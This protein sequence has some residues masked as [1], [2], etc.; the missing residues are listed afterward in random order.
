MVLCTVIAAVFA[1]GVGILIA[2]VG[3]VYTGVRESEKARESGKVIVPH[4]GDMFS[5][6]VF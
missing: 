6:S 4:Y 2:G 5:N 1:A 3:N